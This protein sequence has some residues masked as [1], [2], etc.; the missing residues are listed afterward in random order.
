MKVVLFCG[1][2]GLRLRE[3]SE[4]IPKPMVQIGYRPILWHVMRYYAHY[5]HRDFILC[6]GYRADAIKDYFLH[7]SEAVSNDF[8]LSE[9]GR[10]IELLGSD[11]ED[12]RITFAD[13]GLDTTIGERLR[14]VRHLL[15]GE[16]MF[17]ANYGD[18]LTDAPLDQLVERF[19]ASD[20]MACFSP[21]SRQR[22]TRS[23]CCVSGRT[24]ASKRSCRRAMP[25]SG[26]TV[27]YFMLR[28]RDLRRDRAWRRARRRALCSADRGRP[29]PCRTIPRVLG[30]L[31]TLRDLDS[32]KALAAG[33]RPRGASGAERPW[34]WIAQPKRHARRESVDEAAD[35]GPTGPAARPG[36][37]I[38]IAGAHADDAEIGAGG[39]I[40]RL[41]AERPDAEVT[42][43][44]LAAPI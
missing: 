2:R 18:T 23:M 41:V 21:S 8:V 22:S 9:G 28:P 40:A 7:Y 31:D 30:P 44:V 13:T 17:L 38:L 5:G 36:P 1:G 33:G 4:A 35:Q 24:I 39:T 34:R 43:L 26:S 6:L 42:W 14:R 27:G 3:H 20:A 37:R 12:W 32:S 10:R 11:I 19:R 16:D 15:E 25:T 29:P